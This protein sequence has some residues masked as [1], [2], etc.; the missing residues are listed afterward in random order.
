MKPLFAL[1]L[2]ASLTGP[3]LADE[4]AELAAERARLEARFAAEEAG[5]R[6]RFAEQPTGLG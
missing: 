6:E 2:L 1:L 5:C 4:R 3:A